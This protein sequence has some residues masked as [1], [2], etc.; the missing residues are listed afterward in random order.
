MPQRMR[1]DAT[2]NR[3]VSEMR[4]QNKMKTAHAQ[5]FPQMAE[6]EGVA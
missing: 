6:K 4:L 5:R 3:T 1:R 2:R